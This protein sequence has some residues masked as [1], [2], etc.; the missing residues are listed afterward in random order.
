MGCN[1][2]REKYPKPSGKNP[3]NLPGGGYPDYE[4]APGDQVVQ[5]H[6]AMDFLAGRLE[7]STL[8]TRMMILVDYNRDHKGADT[9]EWIV[10]EPLKIANGSKYGR[11]VWAGHQLAPVVDKNGVDLFHPWREWQLAFFG[12]VSEPTYR[13][14]GRPL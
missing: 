9:R 1:E 13:P 6:D 10:D 11:G 2:P 4:F 14:N 8:I 3:Y 7:M 5:I 12:K